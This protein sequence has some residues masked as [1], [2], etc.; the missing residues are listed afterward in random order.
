MRNDSHLPIPRWWR[1]LA[2]FVAVL[3]NSAAISAASARATAYLPPPGKVFAGVGPGNPAFYERQTQVHP[4]VLQD[5]IPWYG[6]YRWLLARADANHAR[7][8]LAHAQRRHL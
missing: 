7:H 6:A 1:G 4:A 8:D 3:A 5:Y 2:C